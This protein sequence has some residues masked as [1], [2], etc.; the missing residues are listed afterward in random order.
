MIILLSTS[1]ESKAA[2]SVTITQ[3]F[4]LTSENVSFVGG[5]LGTVDLSNGL[6]IVDDSFYELDLDIDMTFES[7]TPLLIRGLVLSQQAER[8]QPL[9]YQ[10]SSS[11]DGT[12]QTNFQFVYND[13]FCMLGSE[14]KN[15]FVVY[16]CNY[17]SE[18][19]GTATVIAKV[20]FTVNGIRELSESNAEDYQSGY[21]AGYAAGEE[22]GYDSG[23]EAGSNSVDTD[24]YYDAGYTAGYNAAI[25]ANH[26]T[27]NWGATSFLGSPTSVTLTGVP[28]YVSSYGLI[29]MEEYQSGSNGYFHNTVPG[30]YTGYTEFTYNVPVMTMNGNSSYRIDSNHF[31]LSIPIRNMSTNTDVDVG[32]ATVSANIVRSDVV[33]AYLT[34]NGQKYWGTV[35]G[36]YVE[37]DLELET[38]ANPTWLDNDSIAITFIVQ[39]SVCLVT[40]AD[41]THYVGACYTPQL[42]FTLG[43]GSYAVYVRPFYPKAELGAVDIEQQTEEIT[44]A[45]EEQKEIQ[46]GQLEQAQEQ[47]ETQKGIFESIKEFFGSF[48]Q[49]LIDSVVGL[50]VPS[51]E[52]MSELFNRLN[53][54][55]A[56]T[57]GFL[58]Y[59][60]DFIIDAFNIFLEADSETGLTLPSF[61]IMGYEVWGDITYDITS[62]PIVGE[63]FGYVRMGTGAM[64]AMWFV[65]Y[66]RNFFDKR[67][68]GGGN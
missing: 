47:T 18:T 9:I 36:S 54:F 20:D 56:E 58:Y 38:F 30:T 41:V 42:S 25:S 26:N 7:D 1:I 64:L 45:L 40:D 43:T 12:Y 3:P 55:F 11:W 14:L 66:L 33:S 22:A 13:T 29:D 59:P 62:E 67:F 39:N 21:D 24:S 17:M 34:Y 23:Y 51:S 53:D 50:F 16:H 63:I 28:Y 10:D 19:T 35:G 57:F 31:N 15:M 37:F 44:G 2:E 68:G 61:S 46:Q 27:G 52:E 48:F 4:Q 65:N 8:F 60:F 6:D 5:A 32:G 49:N